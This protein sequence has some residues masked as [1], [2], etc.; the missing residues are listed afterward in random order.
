MPSVLITFLNTVKFC[1]PNGIETLPP[2]P[3]RS[4]SNIASERNALIFP[5]S[6]SLICPL[7]I[8]LIIASYRRTRTSADPVSTHSAHEPDPVSIF[9]V[10]E[11]PECPRPLVPRANVQL[12]V[13]QRQR[14]TQPPQSRPRM[15]GHPVVA[16]QALHSAPPKRFRQSP[17][18]LSARPKL[19]PAPISV[20]ALMLSLFPHVHMHARKS[21]VVWPPSL[22]L[23]VKASMLLLMRAA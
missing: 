13:L 4:T 20:L 9:V 10:V 11:V 3:S 7:S 22:L 12:H 23:Q 8:S 5:L 16:I 18:R 14:E 15:F 19:P 6:I 2:L 1:R 17:L 21:P